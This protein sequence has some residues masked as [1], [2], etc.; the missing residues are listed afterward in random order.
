MNLDS[1]YYVFNMKNVENNA[2]ATRIHVCCSSSVHSLYD[3]WGRHIQR[4][5]TRFKLAA[6]SYYLAPK[7]VRIEATTLANEVEV[8]WMYHDPDELQE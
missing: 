8:F 3:T 1:R 5:F 4:D 2:V 7:D 6:R